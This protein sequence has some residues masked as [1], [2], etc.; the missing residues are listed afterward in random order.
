MFVCVCDFRTFID[1]PLNFPD[2]IYTFRHKK[3]AAHINP[4]YAIL[5][6]NGTFFCDFK[7]FIDEVLNTLARVDTFRHQNQV[8]SP[9]GPDFSHFRRKWNMFL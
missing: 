9:Y 1:T 3:N 5:G 2:Q 6:Q 7:I 8:S 4:I